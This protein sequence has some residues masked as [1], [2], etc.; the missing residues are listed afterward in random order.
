MSTLLSVSEGETVEIEDRGGTTHQ[1]RIDT[2]S[3]TP[4]DELDPSLFATDGPHKLV[5]ITCGGVFDEQ[6]GRYSENIVVTA[7]PLGP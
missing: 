1:Y 7:E 5:L 2:R 4:K 6:S 3:N